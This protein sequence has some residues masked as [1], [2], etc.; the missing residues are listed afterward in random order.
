MTKKRDTVA[1]RINELDREREQIE[2]SLAQASQSSPALNLE[3][4]RREVAMVALE[5]EKKFDQVPVEEKK[6]LLKRCISKVVIEKDRRI[7][8]FYVR[9][10]PQV[11]ET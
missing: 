11:P 7:S 5:F 9:K 10:V 1:E 3:E 8:R 4:I 2:R 6:E